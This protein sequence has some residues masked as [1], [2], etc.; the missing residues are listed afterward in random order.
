MEQGFILKD[1]PRVVGRDVS[2]PDS[3]S[4][5]AVCSLAGQSKNPERQTMKGTRD[6]ANVFARSR[7]HNLQGFITLFLEDAKYVVSP[8]IYKS[9]LDN[10]NDESKEQCHAPRQSPP[11]A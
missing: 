7:N 5:L 1:K 10:R 2:R 8:D 3:L 9:S 6:K 11:L 4:A